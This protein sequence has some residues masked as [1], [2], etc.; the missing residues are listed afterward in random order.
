MLEQES[1]TDDGK[2]IYAQPLSVLL[3][4]ARGITD[5]SLLFLHLFS[6]SPLASKICERPVLAWHLADILVALLPG[7]L[8]LFF[9]SFQGRLPDLRKPVVEGQKKEAGCTQMFKH[10]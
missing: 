6:P 3:C 10:V 8:T 5:L 2:E 1:S 4:R 7:S 9:C